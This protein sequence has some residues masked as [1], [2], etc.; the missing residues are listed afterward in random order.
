MNV[1]S[2]LYRAQLQDCTH[3]ASAHNAFILVVPER[4]LV[5]YPHQGSRP[6]VAVTDRAFAVAFIA[7]A[8]DGDTGLLATHDEIAREGK[9]AK[10]ILEKGERE[11]Y[12]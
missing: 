2:V 12:G 3:L 4:A 11:T 5:A 7:E 9:S 1:V 6:H 10:D 8:A